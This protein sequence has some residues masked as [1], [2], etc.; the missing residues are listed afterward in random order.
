[1][2]PALAAYNQ[3]PHA[4]G[5]L[6]KF[7]RLFMQDNCLERTNIAFSVTVRPSAIT[8]QAMTA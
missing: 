7:N 1:M 8:L 4:P 2:Q 6:I 5:A 3:A